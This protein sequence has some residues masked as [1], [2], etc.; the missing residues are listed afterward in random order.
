MWV[1]PCATVALIIKHCGVC[2]CVCVCVR[3]F[4]LCCI[5]SF[6]GCCMLDKFLVAMVAG[7]QCHTVPVPILDFISELLV[8]A[9]KGLATVI[10]VGYCYPQKIIPSQI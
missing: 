4:L 9:H 6:I 2:V 8:S 10:T 3:P 7:R 5:Q 1:V